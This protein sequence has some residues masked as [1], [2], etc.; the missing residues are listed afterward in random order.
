MPQVSQP[1]GQ[2]NPRLPSPSFM[3]SGT[4][5]KAA[6]LLHDFVLAMNIPAD[7]KAALLMSF[8]AK[9]KNK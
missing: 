9:E 2:E 1:E 7:Q 4:S 6:A 3:L 8:S 5:Q